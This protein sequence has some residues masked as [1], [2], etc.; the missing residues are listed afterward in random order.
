MVSIGMPVFAG[1][2]H[3]LLTMSALIPVL[4]YR[5][6]IEERLLTE[7]FGD[8]YRSYRDATSK[9]IPFIY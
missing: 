2:L 7:E 6:R 8:A 4:L 3:G 9:L 5:I 1:S